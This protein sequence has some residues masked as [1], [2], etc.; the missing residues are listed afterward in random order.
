MQTKEPEAHSCMECSKTFKDFK[1]AAVSFFIKAQQKQIFSF[2]VILPKS[3]FNDFIQLFKEKN[4]INQFSRDSFFY[5]T[6]NPHTTK[7][8]RIALSDASF[9]HKLSRKYGR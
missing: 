4:Q 5:G 7:R 2:E 9:Q 3:K 8:T 1:R 6:Y